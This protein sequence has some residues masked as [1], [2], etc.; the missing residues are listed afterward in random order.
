MKREREKVK[1]T[2][3]ES[4]VLPILIYGRDFRR[5]C[6]SDKVVHADA[7]PAPMDLLH[8][9]PPTSSAVPI[10]F[11]VSIGRDETSEGSSSQR[12]WSLTRAR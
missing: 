8:P 1:D 2:K 7:K 11:R 6:L 9:P 12:R 5:L 4:G 10:R 3:E